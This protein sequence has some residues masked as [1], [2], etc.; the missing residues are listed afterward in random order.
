MGFVGSVTDCQT[1]GF[2]CE[3][4]LHSLSNPF[5]FNSLA[6]C[7]RMQGVSSPT[8]EHWYQ[9]RASTK[10]NSLELMDHWLYPVPNLGFLHPASS[11]NFRPT[12]GSTLE[13]SERQDHFDRIHGHRA[14][15]R[16]GGCPAPRGLCHPE[17]IG[18]LAGVPPVRQFALSGSSALPGSPACSD[19]FHP[20]S[21][22][23]RPGD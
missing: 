12:G 3:P 8:M 14:R 19:R 18:Y 16:D 10:V 23:H 4:V 1:D 20:S 7:L 5:F 21:A 13:D 17:Y 9:N 2:A 22:R 6:G 11:T 15:H